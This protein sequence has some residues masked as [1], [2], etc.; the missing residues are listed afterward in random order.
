MSW[1]KYFNIALIVVVII[2]FIAFCAVLATGAQKKEGFFA[3][4]VPVNTGNG[5]RF[6]NIG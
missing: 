2:L 3:A 4:G 5:T 6:V 1:K